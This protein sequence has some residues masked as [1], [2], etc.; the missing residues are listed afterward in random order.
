LEGFRP[1]G[2]AALRVGEGRFRVAVINHA[3][4]GDRLELFQLELAGP[5][6]AHLQSLQDEELLAN[7]NDVV[8][9]APEELLVTH[10]HRTKNHTTKLLER[11]LRPGLGY[12]TYWN[13][14]QGRVVLSGFNF[15][16]GIDAVGEG[17]WVVASM[18][19]RKLHKVS[20]ESPGQKL[21]VMTTVT[22]PG[23]PDNV[24]YDAGQQKLWVALH[25]KIFDLKAFSEGKRD[26]SPSRVVTLNPQLE[27]LE[28][29]FA[30]SAPEH[31]AIST[32]QP[33]RHQV[34]LGNIYSGHLE[35]CNAR[36]ETVT[37]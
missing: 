20:W 6:L 21:K 16:N 9:L 13:K 26:T 19:D 31:A 2:L 11:F 1:H 34:V 33:W 8:F 32:A 36:V 24:R 14:G 4:R 35:L 25:E 12:V 23:F 28:T 17:S 7:A 5:S 18:L 22:T 10:D 3:P 37:R 29:V 15:A 27:A 30:S